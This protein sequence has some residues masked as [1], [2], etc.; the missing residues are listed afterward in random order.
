MQILDDVIWEKEKSWLAR[1]FKKVIDDSLAIYYSGFKAKKP[2]QCLSQCL[3]LP[4][5]IPSIPKDFQLHSLPPRD[6]QFCAI[7][8][9][10]ESRWRAPSRFQQTGW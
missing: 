1:E 4:N 8:Q 3:D 5:Q 7:A 10:N 9:D 2:W 6:F